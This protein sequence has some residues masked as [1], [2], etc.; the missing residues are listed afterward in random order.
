MRAFEL[1]LVAPLETA[2][3]TITTRAGLLVSLEDEAGRIGTGEATPLPAFGGED[4]QSCRGALAA[5]LRRLV[6][7][8]DERG[9]RGRSG[10]G[11]EGDGLAGVVA[12]SKRASPATPCAHAAIEAALADL[13]AQ[14]AGR[15]LAAWLRGRSGLPGEP[16][17][18][19]RVQA[20]VSGATPEAVHAA[21]ARSLAAGFGT[22]KLKL[23]VSP[24]RR[25][26]APDLERVAALRAAIGDGGRIRLDANEAWRPEE[27]ETFLAQL[28][29]FDIELIEQP[30]ARGDLAALAQLART[31]PIAI[32]ADEALLGGGLEACLARR[33]A[34]IFV[35]KPSLIGVEGT[36]SLAARA[37]AAGIRIVY[38]NLIEG[39]VGRGLALALAA[40]LAPA[41]GD[42]VHGLGT[43]SLLARDLE[44]GPG[45]PASFLVPGAGPGLGTSLGPCW[46][47]D[48]A[49][50]GALERFE[51]D[52]RAA[53][54]RGEGEAEG[55]C[56][57][58][59]WI[60]QIASHP[61]DREALVFADRAHSWS[62]L[63][64]AA[65]ATADRL[66]GIGLRAGD[67][68]AV[69]APPS[70]A[71]VVLFHALLE[72]RIVLMPVNTRLTEPEIVR[73]LAGAAVSA[74]FVSDAIDPALARRV[75]AAAGCA[76]VCFSASAAELAPA[77]DR[78]A[79]AV[80]AIAATGS[81]IGA[82]PGAATGS[83]PGE[84]AGDA[85]RDALARDDAA[86]VLL[87][88]GT[89]GRSKAAVLGFDNLIASAEASARLLGSEA[90]D[91]WLLCMPLFHIAGL[92]ILVRAARSGACVVLEPRFEAAQIAALV[93]AQ[94]ITQISLVATTLAQ[95]LEA[96]GDR[97]APAS[98]RVVLVGGGPA[99]ES[100]LERAIALGYPIAPTYGLTEAASQVATRPPR[101]QGGLVALPGVEVRIV[102]GADQPVPVGREGE[103]QLR[104]PIV[105]RGYLGDPEATARALRG[106]WLATGDVGRLD[107]AGGLRILDRRSDL[108]L[109]G[110]ENV[111]PAEIESV[112]AEHPD[113]VEAGVVGVADARFGARP[114]AFVVWRA[115][116][117]RDEAR[118]AAWCRTRLAGYKVPIAFR[119]VE[120]LPRNASGKLLRRMLAREAAGQGGGD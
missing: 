53:P 50:F 52:R 77:L 95:L 87:T 80:D 12:S 55:V 24:E 26:L 105:M 78:I 36:L 4:L 14:R 89:S 3:G 32:A 44:P 51:A 2:H 29:R 46:A 41:E 72:R 120:A 96:R 81:A 71:G 15:S 82:E 30:V 8:R 68:V 91:R 67:L 103:I 116:A 38:S 11:G 21:A 18:R 84:S 27:A 23:A 106:G 9:E 85:R 74:L 59:G 5:G 118:L 34:G 70:P 47:L 113:I 60:A 22:F 19:V 56:P 42:E 39:S 17:S 107:A 6:D 86:L 109:S 83:A 100:L 76:L 119:A 102:D 108:I 64:R 7:G 69:L 28:A 13:A 31:S 58:R 43:A 93:E 104:G 54:P 33:A 45:T 48:G 25:D 61:G 101:A 117:A 114:F 65:R 97:P 115:G 57:A 62:E 73:A 90:S 63:V 75:A 94:E 1:P 112:L 92:S 88:S 35:V 37:R 111:Y 66:A 99:P 110:G 20:L 79:G 10:E 49:P 40:G 16:A 98:L